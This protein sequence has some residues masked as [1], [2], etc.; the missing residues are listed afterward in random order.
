VS[1]RLVPVERV[2][3]ALQQLQHVQAARAI[4]RQRLSGLLIGLREG[5][6]DGDAD[7]IANKLLKIRLFENTETG[8]AWDH[9][10]RG[11]RYRVVEW[12]RSAAL[13]TGT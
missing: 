1:H 4:H 3:R 13:E 11:P 10:V 9:S 7:Y 6:D 12:R 5:D 2:L 8:K